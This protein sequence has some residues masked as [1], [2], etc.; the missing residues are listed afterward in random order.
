[1][2]NDYKSLPDKK[3]ARLIHIKFGAMPKRMIGNIWIDDGW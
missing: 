2:N 3:P 1:M